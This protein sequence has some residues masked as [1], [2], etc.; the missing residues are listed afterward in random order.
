[1]FSVLLRRITISGLRRGLSGS[2]GWLL[3]GVA[4]TSVRLL[5]HLARGDEEVVYRTIVRDGDVLE[6]LARRPKRK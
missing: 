4:A 5:R 1:M 3:L 6:V 2:R